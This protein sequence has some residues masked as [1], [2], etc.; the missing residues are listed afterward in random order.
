MWYLHGS[1]TELLLNEAT[2]LRIMYTRRACIDEYQASFTIISR[3]LSKSYRWSWYDIGYVGGPSA[4]I[5]L[6]FHKKHCSVATKHAYAAN[7]AI[8]VGPG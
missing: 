8:A 6:I 2:I 1:P 7:E 3:T 5:P 4:I